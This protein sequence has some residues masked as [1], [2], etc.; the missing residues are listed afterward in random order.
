[1]NNFKKTAAFA[2]AIRSDSPLVIP[3]AY[4]ALSALLIERAGFSATYI[5]SFATAASAFGLPDVGVLTLTEMVDHVRKIAR[6]TQL[7]VLADGEAGFF[8]APNIWRTVSAFEDAGAVGIHVEDNLG[9][10]HS[11]APAGL[12]P[13]DIMIPRLRAAAEAKSDPNFQIIARSDALWVFGDLEDCVSRLAAYIDAGADAVF[14]PGM[15]AAQLR[16]VRAKLDAPVM[17]LGDLPDN[18]GLPRSWR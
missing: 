18:R 5:G 9:G 15:S 13:V 12:V 17:V 2:E 10:K 6:A 1:M 8:D 3:G 11:S 7:P 16:R 14:A 4:D